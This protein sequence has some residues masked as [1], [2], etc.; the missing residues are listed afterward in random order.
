MLNFYFNPEVLLETTECNQGKAP[1]LEFSSKGHIIE[2]ELETVEAAS[3]LA[4]DMFIDLI[5][6]VILV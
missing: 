4:D 5:H 1:K 3:L 6:L 2:F